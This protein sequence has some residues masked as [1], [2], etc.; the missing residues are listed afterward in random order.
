MAQRLSS[1]LLKCWHRW[2][3]TETETNPPPGSAGTEIYTRVTETG[4]GWVGGFAKLYHPPRL[5]LLHPFMRRAFRRRRAKNTEPVGSGVGRSCASSHREEVNN[6]FIEFE[7]AREAQS[8]A[9]PSQTLSHAPSVSRPHPALLQSSTVS[10]IKLKECGYIYF[11][12]QL[13]S[14]NISKKPDAHFCLF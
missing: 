3:G 8:S 2:P 7:A 6:L 12:A 4:K 13:C 14:D 1:H 9:Q 10:K 5:F 11:L